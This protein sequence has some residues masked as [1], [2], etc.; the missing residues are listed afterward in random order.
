MIEP[1]ACVH[2]AT[3]IW[4]YFGLVF[5]SVFLYSWNISG[6]LSPKCL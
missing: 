5:F 4:Q 1:L 6:Y 3:H 2:S